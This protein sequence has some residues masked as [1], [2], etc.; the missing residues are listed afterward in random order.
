MTEMFSPEV[1]GLASALITL[2]AAILAL[3]GG[4]RR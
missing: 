2:L 3:F 1:I 4:R